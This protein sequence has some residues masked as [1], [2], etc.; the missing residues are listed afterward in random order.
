MP[1]N[2]LQSIQ[3]TKRMRL[4]FKN[5]AP[6][7]HE[8]QPYKHLEV[9]PKLWRALSISNHLL[10]LDSP[11]K[12]QNKENGYQANIAF[13]LKFTMT[14]ITDF[15][16]TCKPCQLSQSTWKITSDLQ[17]VLTTTGKLCDNIS[18]KYSTQFSNTR[19]WRIWTKNEAP[20]GVQ[21]WKK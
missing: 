4:E 1:Q 15:S 17:T 20:S 13:F 9:T 12:R 14:S 19:I 11:E 2:L 18:Q 7:R 8:D 16:G 21:I 6:L 10:T 5:P 3:V